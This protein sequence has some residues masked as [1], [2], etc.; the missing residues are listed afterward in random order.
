MTVKI[1]WTLVEY[2]LFG[3]WFL[4]YTLYWINLTQDWRLWLI[5]HCHDGN[6]SD[7]WP[8]HSQCTVF[9]PDCIWCIQISSGGQ[10]CRHSMEQNHHTTDVVLWQS[11]GL[12]FH[13][14]RSKNGRLFKEERSSLKRKQAFRTLNFTFF[15]DILVER[16]RRFCLWIHGS[17]C[18]GKSET[19]CYLRQ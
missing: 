17:V 8:L 13:Y 16:V 1:L 4:S 14:T 3:D 19:S 9:F 12:L 15:V 7:P 10:L 2:V 6:I 18:W 5:I 11:I